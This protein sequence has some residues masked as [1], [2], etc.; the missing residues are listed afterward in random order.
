M[1]ASLS[2]SEIDFCKLVF[3]F[4]ISGLPNDN[5]L[6]NRSND[7]I[8]YL[9]KKTEWLFFNHILLSEDLERLC[10]TMKM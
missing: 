10:G 9:R 7:T 3:F 8:K 5:K 6:S 1:R 2:T 4:S